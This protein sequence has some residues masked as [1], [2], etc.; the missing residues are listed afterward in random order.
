MTAVR[1]DQSCCSF[2]WSKI[3]IGLRTR[4]CWADRPF[5]GRCKARRSLAKLP[6][7]S[8]VCFPSQPPELDSLKT[9]LIQVPCRLLPKRRCPWI[10]M[11]KMPSRRV[12]IGSSNGIVE[13]QDHRHP[14]SERRMLDAPTASQPSLPPGVAA[15]RPHSFIHRGLV[16]ILSLP[17]KL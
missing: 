16:S 1:I 10:R 2:T 6:S 14:V 7:P 13:N 11:Q 17:S 5:E 8:L 12:P 3:G 4:C 15:G 9:G